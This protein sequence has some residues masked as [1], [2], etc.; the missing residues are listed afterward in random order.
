MRL[1]LA[2]SRPEKDRLDPGPTALDDCP[3]FER[4]ASHRMLI[5]VEEGIHVDD[6]CFVVR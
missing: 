2:K 5:I 3:G 1:V 4:L 6:G